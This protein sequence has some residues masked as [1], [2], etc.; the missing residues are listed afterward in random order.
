MALWTK[1]LCCSYCSTFII[2][3][4]AGARHMEFPGQGSDLSRNCDLSHNCSNA[5]S[6]THYARLGSNL[7][8]STPKMLLTILLCHSRN[9]CSNLISPRVA[10]YKYYNFLYCEKR[11]ICILFMHLFIH[12]TNCFEH[13]FI[14]H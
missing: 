10:E 3:W 4:G 6:L 8:S 7:C 12:S 5:G 2:I 14:E 9:S 11:G 13:M 1:L